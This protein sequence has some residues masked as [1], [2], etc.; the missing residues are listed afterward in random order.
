MSADGSRAAVAFATQGNWD[1]WTID[2]ERGLPTRATSHAGPD[3]DPVWSRDGREVFFSSARGGGGV[4]RLYRKRQDGTGPATLMH[5]TS[6]NEFPKAVTPDGTALLFVTGG[7]PSNDSVWALPLVGEGDP[8]LILKVTYSLDD[9]QV[10]PDGR[11]LAYCANDTGGWEVY[12]M[13]YGR[14]G[15]RI[16]VSLGGGRQ[17]RWRG[18]SR[19]LFYVT[20]EGE[21]MVVPV[22]ESGDGLALGRGSRLFNAG[23]RSRTRSQYGVTRDGQRFLVITPVDGDRRSLEVV[24]N[25]PSLLEQ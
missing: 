15:E 16:P 6:Q 18:D 4:W 21:L 14:D 20:P 25:W 17:P 2:L 22:R 7:P 12:L 8:K 10:S 11:W 19:E 13:P 1:V 24:L 23:V 9:P 3:G 5:D